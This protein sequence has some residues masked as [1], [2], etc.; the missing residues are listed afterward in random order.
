ME[1]LSN[2]S[3][4]AI[5]ALAAVGFIAG[6]INAVVSSG[7]LLSIPDLLTLGLLTHLTLGTN[8]PASSFSSYMSAWTYYRKHFMTP[9]F[10]LQASI[11]SKPDAFIGA[12]FAILFGL[13]FVRPLFTTM[14]IM[15]VASL[16]WRA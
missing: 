9:E 3:S 16:T 7:G 14:V 13:P 8:K 10:R 5:L 6:F 1:L 12:R 4:L 2:P 11:A 15:I